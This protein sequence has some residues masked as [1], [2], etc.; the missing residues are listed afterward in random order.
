MAKEK[1]WTKFEVVH[2]ADPIKFRD[3]LNALNEELAIYKPKTTFN[4][5]PEIYRQSSSTKWSKQ[6]PKTRLKS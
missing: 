2:E 1:R 3:K 5:T 4:I 6:F